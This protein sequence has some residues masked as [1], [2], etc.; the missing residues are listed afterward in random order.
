M[1][2]TSADVPSK[3]PSLQQQTIDQQINR[4]RPYP[5]DYQWVKDL[6]KC[7]LKLVYKDMQPF[8]VVEDEAFREL[9][10]LLDPKYQLPSRTKV[11]SNL[12]SMYSVEKERV[13]QELN[14]ALSISLTTD[15]WTSRAT[16]GY[17]TTTAHY[18]TSTWQS[19]TA[20]NIAA[21]LRSIIDTWG[22]RG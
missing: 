1:P 2:S 16:Q 12:L 7:V 5:K 21:V 4:K 22:M 11:S 13:Q 20:E 14:N 6:D 8:S 10:E 18:I 17:I 3:A 9:V 15:M 19:H